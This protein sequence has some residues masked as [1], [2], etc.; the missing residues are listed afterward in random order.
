MCHSCKNAGFLGFHR[1]VGMRTGGPVST[2]PH[3]TDDD[4]GDDNPCSDDEEVVQGKPDAEDMGKAITKFLD[5]HW[6]TG[7]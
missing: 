3:V 4:E 7:T 6:N 1:D 2:Q 5:M